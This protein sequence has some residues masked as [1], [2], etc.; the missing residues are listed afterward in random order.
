MSPSTSASTSSPSSSFSPSSSSPSSSVSGAQHPVTRSSCVSTIRQEVKAF[1]V[2]LVA[3]LRASASAVTAGSR[4]LAAR[5]QTPQPTEAPQAERPS[6]SS[7]P[8]PSSSPA[9]HVSLSGGTARSAVAVAVGEGE[10]LL[11]ASQTLLHSLC[12]LSPSAPWIDEAREREEPRAAAAPSTS[13]EAKR[14]IGLQ[15][16]KPVVKLAAKKLAASFLSLHELAMQLVSFL[17][18]FEARHPA[19]S[20]PSSEIDARAFR[21]LVE[22]LFPVF[23]TLLLSCQRLHEV[24]RQR[25]CPKEADAASSF[26]SFLFGGALVPAVRFLSLAS[27]QTSSG[28]LREI[29]AFLRLTLSHAWPL[30]LLAHIDAAVIA[31][32][33]SGS[34]PYSP[35][36]SPCS[37]APSL[38][39][40]SSSSLSSSSGSGDGG[41][42]PPR[43][44]FLESSSVR[45]SQL[46][47]SCFLQA[48]PRVRGE[49][50]CAVV[51]G[52]A[53]HE[54][55]Q[56]LRASAA[57]DGEALLLVLQCLYTSADIL[58]LPL[59]L[60]VSPPGGHHASSATAPGSPHS[61]PSLF[62]CSV[63]GPRHPAQVA[64][65]EESRLWTRALTIQLYPGVVTAVSTF[66]LS[67]SGQRPR[68]LALALLVLARWISALFRAGSPRPQ[69]PLS[70]LPH[71]STSPRSSPESPG[72]STS[73]SFPSLFVSSG[74]ERREAQEHLDW[75]RGLTKDAPGTLRR[76]RDAHGAELG[77]EHGEAESP[78]NNAQ[79]H[80]R[81]T[82]KVSGFPLL[83]QLQQEAEERRKTQT[84]T[85]SEAEKRLETLLREA[86]RHTSEKLLSLLGPLSPLPVSDWRV[87]LARLCLAASLVGGCREILTTTSVSAATDVLLQSFAD[88]QEDLAKHARAALTHNRLSLPFA[89]D[90]APLSSYSSSSAFHASPPPDRWLCDLL[91]PHPSDA[92]A[93]QS[94]PLCSSSFLYS[95]ASPLSSS[96]YLASSASPAAPHSALSSSSVAS[97]AVGWG[98][99]APSLPPAVADEEILGGLKLR[100]ISCLEAA[101]SAALAVSSPSSSS[102]MPDCSPS[103]SP[104]TRLRRQQILQTELKKVGGYLRLMAASSSPS[105]PCSTPRRG[106]QPAPEPLPEGLYDRP[107]FGPFG[108]ENEAISEEERT[109]FRPNL[110]AWL[111]PSERLLWSVLKLAL[112]QPAILS[113]RMQ[114]HGLVESRAFFR[115]GDEA[116][117][118]SVTSSRENG[119]KETLLLLPL[120]LRALQEDP[121]SCRLLPRAGRRRLQRETTV[122]T[123]PAGGEQESEDG[124]PMQR[125]TGRSG[126][127]DFTPG[128]SDIP[129]CPGCRHFQLSQR[130]RSIC[131]CYSSSSSSPSQSACS[132][133]CRESEWSSACAPDEACDQP[134]EEDFDAQLVSPSFQG[135]GGDEALGGLLRQ[136]LEALFAVLPAPSRSALFSDLLS[137]LSSSPESIEAACSVPPAP[138]DA[139]PLQKSKHLSTSSPTSETQ[140]GPALPAWLR[141]ASSQTT[142]SRH[143]ASAD[144]RSSPSSF[145]ASSST[146]SSACASPLSSSSARQTFSSSLSGSVSPPSSVGRSSAS[147]FFQED[148]V[149][150]T[151]RVS[152][153]SRSPLGLLLLLRCASLSALSAALRAALLSLSHSSVERRRQTGGKQR[154]RAR[155]CARANSPETRSQGEAGDGESET[156]SDARG[157]MR[158]AGHQAQPA[159][160]VACPLFW[161]T[162]T[163]VGG[164]LGREEGQ[165]PG[166]VFGETQESALKHKN[167]EEGDDANAF[168]CV[169]NVE[170]L[171]DLLLDANAVVAGEAQADSLTRAL[172]SDVSEAVEEEG[173]GAFQHETKGAE[174]KPQTP[175]GDRDGPAAQ[176][177]ER[178][179]AESKREERQAGTDATKTLAA[180]SVL[181]G[182]DNSGVTVRQRQGIRGRAHSPE[183]VVCPQTEDQEGNTR[184]KSERGTGQDEGG[185][186][187]QENKARG[188]SL[189]ANRNR[190][191]REREATLRRG[192]ERQQRRRSAAAAIFPLARAL[193]SFYRILLLRCLDLAL[194]LL[195]DLG[196]HAR[197]AKLL[198]FLLFPLYRH[199]GSHSSRAV[200]A[201]AYFALLSLHSALTTSENTPVSPPPASFPR[202]S[203][204]R[205]FASS[206]SSSPSSSLAFS[207]SPATSPLGC[208]L[209]VHG[210]L[211]LDAVADCL[212]RPPSSVASSGCRAALAVP[213]ALIA[214][215]GGPAPRGFA[216][217]LAAVTAA[218]VGPP[219]LAE[220]DV[221][222]LLLALVAFAPPAMLPALSD[223]VEL[224]LQ[225]Q[226]QLKQAQLQSV[227][228]RLSPAVLGP[229]QGVRFA[230]ESRATKALQ[231]TLVHEGGGFECLEREEGETPLWLL[232]VL[233]ALSFL[234]TRRVADDRCH[235]RRNRR[236]RRGRERAA[237]GTAGETE[238]GAQILERGA[239]LP[240]GRSHASPP[241]QEDVHPGAA[242]RFA[243]LPA[244]F[245]PP[246]AWL[247]SPARLLREREKEQ[248]LSGRRTKGLLECGVKDEEEEGAATRPVSE[249]SASS[250]DEAEEDTHEADM[251]L[252]GF[253]EDLAVDLEDEE[254][255]VD[256]G[257][258][259]LATFTEA[260]GK[261]Q[262][263]EVDEDLFLEEMKRV[264]ATGSDGDVR[265]VLEKWKHKLLAEQQ[266][267]K[268]RKE[269]TG[270][271]ANVLKPRK[272]WAQL[273]RYG[274]LRL[275][276]TRILM[277]V[278]LLLHT[279][280][281][282]TAGVYIHLT[283]LRCIYVLTT[284]KRELLPRIHEIWPSLLPSLGP[285][286]P[287]PVLVI[288]LA[289]IQLMAACAGSFVRE[290]FASDVLPPLLLRLRRTS[291]PA[292]SREEASRTEAFKL[293]HA[294][295]SLLLLLATPSNPESFLY[296]V[297]GEVLFS[298]CFHLHRDAASCLRAQACRLL[299][300]LNCIDP[301][302]PLFV[303]STLT[304][305]ASRLQTSP[306]ASSLSSSSTST[307]SLC[308]SSPSSSSFASSVSSATCSSLISMSSDRLLRL[309]SFSTYRRN[310]VSVETWRRVA[311]AASLSVLVEL[312]DEMQR[313]QKLHFLSSAFASRVTDSAGAQQ[314]TAEAAGASYEGRHDGDETGQREVEEL[315]VLTAEALQTP[316][317]A[318]S[319]EGM[320]S[321]EGKRR[322]R[323]RRNEAGWAQR[324]LLSVPYGPLGEGFLQM[325]AD[326]EEKKEIHNI[327]ERCK[328]AI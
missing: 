201:A 143:L 75:L 191:E 165:A 251:P 300:R 317:A 152:P 112:A 249:A 168:F 169:S 235:R 71:P 216:P 248:L 205:P 160:A 66:L 301:Q 64:E 255:G 59:S 289:I 30:H 293:G 204:S 20:S 272:T 128:H 106:R 42:S 116:A 297:L 104:A 139:Q 278:R 192:R 70:V 113:Q 8:P 10:K 225:R 285:S 265:G 221:A 263:G 185:Q 244:R 138:A 214:S 179:A 127:T 304:E 181:L 94:G 171:I 212:H 159:T 156:A 286:A 324:S 320:E 323:R 118:T 162:Y 122:K 238:G 53:L 135:A 151:A 270:K 107:A 239:D 173:E 183:T 41:S 195:G 47:A 314:P 2:A 256:R 31:S 262:G 48:I 275:H 123:P 184:E 246:F 170:F 318:C 150:A 27:V 78:A 52:I 63:G 222:A 223:L 32:L 284:R 38:S 266:R 164:Q 281:R 227:L 203:P 172:A 303:I 242:S 130:R 174:G 233:A 17:E 264:A 319:A 65:S 21:P 247:L 25:R 155:E 237:R 154:Q 259:A 273:G 43:G 136:T 37:A 3:F 250:E 57:L 208:L 279:D 257:N 26:L 307:S 79:A 49:L 24:Y 120:Q 84:Q 166:P 137:F 157:C 176:I 67:A 299:R 308:S 126:T 198:P 236:A 199:L 276:A 254:A 110:H 9:L 325:Q 220:S 277:R 292:G 125:Y 215:S 213:A 108:L 188:S 29:L 129:L 182:A 197:V 97:Y 158:R 321:S 316:A 146:S 252:W 76:P 200:A 269:E 44:G 92:R 87:R 312:R 15:I 193:V 19:S 167:G 180:E 85:P 40:E 93:S 124:R 101:A 36:S 111:L 313:D 72:A 105:S 132:H 315:E 295:L 282:P 1:E 83:A 142:Q 121:L 95:T 206:F 58:D 189:S 209:S 39:P 177:E 34:S 186:G 219:R 7:S 100:F 18:R 144:A 117:T 163:G 280:P 287:P 16:E 12:L 153:L 145:S 241:V 226:S 268:T 305:V 210:D 13:E 45:L 202:V 261:A 328:R 134:R 243:E 224:L 114:H 294:W 89:F 88:D 271:H 229:S 187:E 175:T 28:C 54:L 81:Q 96:S 196:E 35:S 23:A 302:V 102:T 55:L 103:F 230:I 228:A 140:T 194:Q 69:Q 322:V 326:Q 190:E 46:A 234:L 283:A 309:V 296:S 253:D 133:A 74:E 131:R 231:T 311:E 60:A 77:E 260:E 82:D 22:V 217:F 90:H 141:R 11:A 5:R 207:S 274:S 327:R 86:A 310:L 50:P 211:L 62:L 218:S 61:L 258:D 149:D 115:C 178:S 80:A 232:R 109:G 98:V 68:A 33:P 73:S 290:R 6:S 306:T 240:C 267:A 51:L 91:C 4:L 119:E 14:G 291:Q 288:T 148:F 56:L 147:P 298:A 245:P 99:C 161:C